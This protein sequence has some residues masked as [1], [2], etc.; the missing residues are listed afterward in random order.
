M[1]RCDRDGSVMQSTFLGDCMTRKVLQTVWDERERQ[2]AQYGTNSELRDGTG[3]DA[4]WIPEGDHSDCVATERT[5]RDD[6]ESHM[7]TYGAV[8]WMHLVREEVAE[9]FAEDDP[10]KLEAELIQVAALCVS[11]VE[12][13]RERRLA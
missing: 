4:A 5:M 8:T 1:D 3:P 12:K 9:A 2:F 10:E 13:I 11:W 6:Y 7:A